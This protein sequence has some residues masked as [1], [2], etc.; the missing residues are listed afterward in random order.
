MNSSY[1][2]IIY[3]NFNGNKR[4]AKFVGC[5][6]AWNSNYW[7]RIRLLPK[8]IFGR[9]EMHGLA[10]NIP[11]VQFDWHPAREPYDIPMGVR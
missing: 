11:W 2:E 10:Y 9:L 3:N 8:P 4:H 7:G 5:R 1:N 6:N